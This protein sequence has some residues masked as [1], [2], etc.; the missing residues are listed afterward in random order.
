[1]SKLLTRLAVLGAA[2]AALA[3]A[4]RMAPKG[5]PEWAQS[6]LRYIESHDPLITAIATVLLTCVTGGLV[7]L[8]YLQIRTTRAQLRAYVFPESAMLCDG[9]ALNPPIPAKTNEPGVV[10]GQLGSTRSHRAFK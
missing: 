7:F 4:L 5:S 10:C 3:L 1:M 2:I 8:T 9:M 6:A